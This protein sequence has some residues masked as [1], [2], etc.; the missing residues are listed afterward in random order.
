MWRTATRAVAA[1]FFAAIVLLAACGGQ[2][3]TGQDSTSQDSAGQDP[4]G[5]DPTGQDPALVQG[6]STFEANCSTCHGQTGEGQ[7]DWHVRKADGTLPAPP[8]NGD[9]HTWHHG[10]GTL[11]TYVSRG[12]VIYETPGFRSGMPAFE[13]KLS[14][15]EIVSVIE[16]V[17]SLWGDKVAEGPGVVKRESQAAVSIN[18]PFPEAP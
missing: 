2:D 14:H 3:S 17:K 10:D 15:Q 12:G 1:A 8:L 5:Q 9:G 16:Y 13:G 18:D 11:Y 7:P 6:R 4:T